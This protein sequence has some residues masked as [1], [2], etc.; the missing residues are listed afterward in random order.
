MK[1]QQVQQLEDVVF[2]AWDKGIGDHPV[3][4]NGDMRN[5]DNSKK[6]ILKINNIMKRLSQPAASVT[7]TA[8]A[9]TDIL[10]LSTG[11]RYPSGYGATSTAFTLSTTGVLPAG[12]SAA[13]TYFAIDVSSNTIKVASSLA[14]SEAGTAINITDAGTGVHTLTLIVPTRIKKWANN[15]TYG[16]YAID[17]TGRVWRHATG[18]KFSLV[19]GNTLTNGDGSGIAIY[20]DYLFVWRLNT[21]DCMKLADGTW[22]NGWQSMSSQSTSEHFPISGIDDAVYFVDGRY[23]GSIEEVVSKTFDPADGTTFVYTAQALDLPSGLNATC[24]TEIGSLLLVHTNN[25]TCY[26]WDRISSTYNDPL[27]I[28]AKGIY[29][30]ITVED[31]CYILA[32]KTNSTPTFF[33][34]NGYT[35]KF[36]RLLPRYLFNPDVTSSSFA[37]S[38]SGACY[39]KNRIL[40]G[41]QNTNIP[42]GGNYGSGIYSLDLETQA[43]QFERKVTAGYGTVSGISF[44]TLFTKS[45]IVYAS[46]NNGADNKIGRAS[47]RERV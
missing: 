7:F 37:A 29:F 9:S 5:C 28:P 42:T 46:W 3:S 18:V 39:L 2:N 21:I 40:F 6:G 1:R 10:T 25:D 38:P 34:T 26:P 41:M 43:V 30:A 15:I 35:T 45:N 12:L 11:I 47:C 31:V 19:A 17:S 20:K 16:T 36:L 27:D 23:V 14:N 44:D 24:L 32:G 4:G 33:V 8:D 22:T 13:T